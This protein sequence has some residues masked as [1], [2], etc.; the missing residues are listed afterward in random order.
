MGEV[1][2]Q[3]AVAH[4]VLLNGPLAVDGD[5]TVQDC[6]GVVRAGLDWK[7]GGE[8]IEEGLVDPPPFCV[9]FVV[10]RVRGDVAVSGGGVGV[11]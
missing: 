2:Q 3:I 10:P 4:H 8:N 5:Q 7:F 1:A 11:L 9:R 6:A